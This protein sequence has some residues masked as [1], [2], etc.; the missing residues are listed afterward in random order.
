MHRLFVPAYIVASAPSFN[1]DLP[2]TRPRADCQTSKQPHQTSPLSAEVLVKRKHDDS[3][4]C[5]RGQFGGGDSPMARK[6]PDESHEK[7]SSKARTIASVAINSELLLER[8]NAG[9]Y[10]VKTRQYT[11]TS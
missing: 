4:W 8:K 9:P 3:R 11:C 5:P 10:N 1:L 7:D 2:R 6:D